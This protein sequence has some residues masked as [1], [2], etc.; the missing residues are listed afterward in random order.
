MNND[1]NCFLKESLGGFEKLLNTGI[2]LL[3]CQHC[4]N[5]KPTNTRS[6]FHKAGSMKTQSHLTLK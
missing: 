2:K 6:P 4:Q 1:A 5:S 3:S